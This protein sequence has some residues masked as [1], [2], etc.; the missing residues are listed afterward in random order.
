MNYL[1]LILIFIVSSLCAFFIYHKTNAS[2]FLV[3]KLKINTRKK[4]T[5][6]DFVSFTVGVIIFPN[7]LF[8]YKDIL[9]SVCLFIVIIICGLSESLKRDMTNNKKKR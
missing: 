5:I 1:G 3:D 8:N 4:C 6:I 9:S 7:V 2:K